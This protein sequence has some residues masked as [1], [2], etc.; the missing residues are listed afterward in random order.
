MTGPIEK[1]A[2]KYL[3]PKFSGQTE[4]FTYYLSENKNIP[5]MTFLGGPFI[6]SLI[7][8]HIDIKNISKSVG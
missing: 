4:F 8:T 2:L 6:L 1:E 3:S 7:T 5:L